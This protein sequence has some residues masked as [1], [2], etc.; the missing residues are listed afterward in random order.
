[1]GALEVRVIY[2]DRVEWR[3]SDGTV[4]RLGGVVEG[5]SP[6]AQRL[7]D[8][9]ELL[10]LGRAASVTTRPPP[11]GCEELNTSD[12]YHVA[13]WLEDWVRFFDGVQLLSAPALAPRQPQRDTE[14]DPNTVY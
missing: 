2:T 5:N 10:P 3:F 12:P 6:F 1:V 8:Q 14:A 9:L 13:S 4:V 7:Q 11:A